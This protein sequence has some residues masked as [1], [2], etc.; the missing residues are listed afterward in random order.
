MSC[1]VESYA[2]IEAINVNALIRDFYSLKE[3]RSLIKRGVNVEGNKDLKW[4]IGLI[5]RDEV[6]GIESNSQDN[7]RY[8]G[9]GVKE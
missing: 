1:P 6:Q 9:E 8:D 3:K 2:E 7:T 5:N 4:K